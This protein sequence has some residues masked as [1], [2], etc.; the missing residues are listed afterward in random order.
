MLVGF[1]GWF[2]W[3]F[4]DFKVIVLEDISHHSNDTAVG[5]RISFGYKGVLCTSQK[6]ALCP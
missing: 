3:S 5:S 4:F 1:A 6:A 2:D